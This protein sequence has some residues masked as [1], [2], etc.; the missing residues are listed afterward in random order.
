MKNKSSESSKVKQDKKKIKA[1]IKEILLYV[2]KIT[3]L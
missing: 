3:E 1:K 2:I